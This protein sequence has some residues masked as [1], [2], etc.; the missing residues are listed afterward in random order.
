MGI[1][2]KDVAKLRLG[3]CSDLGLEIK[4]EQ[5]FYDKI[6]TYGY[7][8][9][10]NQY[11][12]HFLK[13]EMDQTECFKANTTFEALYAFYQLDQHLKNEALIDLQLFE[14]SFKAALVDTVEIE[15][16]TLQMKAVKSR[17]SAHSKLDDFLKEKYCLKSGRG[18]RRG[19][20]QSR[21][22]RIKN[23]YHEPFAGYTELHHEITPWVLIKEMSFGVAC[24]YFFLLHHQV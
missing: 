11:G 24:N 2:L 22:R 8:E 17:K 4:N 20:L 13:K 21:I 19:D 14:Q 18:I 10:I 1:N 3:V 23:N 9:I 16:A 6:E 12:P 7:R 15:Q 5:F